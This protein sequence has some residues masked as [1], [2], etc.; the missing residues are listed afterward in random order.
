MSRNR[1]KRLRSP[2]RVCGSPRGLQT[3]HINWD[4]ADNTSTNLMS[5]CEYCHQQTTRLG[6]DL[7]DE[8]LAKADN[9]PGIRKQLRARSDERY[10]SLPQYRKTS[11][12]GG[13]H[14]GFQLPFSDA[15]VSG[16]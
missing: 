4:H 6:K 1:V 3:H 16:Q 8:L 12:G 2:C 9:I 15:D 10:Q 11:T 5:L 14:D 7:F 13:R